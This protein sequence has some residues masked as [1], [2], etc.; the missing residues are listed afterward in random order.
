MHILFLTS[1][2][3]PSPGHMG[4]VNVAW[5]I[6]AGL[7]ATGVQVSVCVLRRGTRFEGPE[8]LGPLSG[9]EVKV[10]FP[11]PEPARGGVW[12][13]LL[14]FGLEES[15][16]EV[17]FRPAVKRLVEELGPDSL[18]LFTSR[19]VAA[20]AGAGRWPPRIVLSETLE[21]R[22][23][24]PRLAF[25]LKYQAGL[26]RYWDA[27]RAAMRWI[28]RSIHS[29]RLMSLCDQVV[30]HADHEAA[31]LRSHG[32]PQASYLPQPMGE[33]LAKNGSPRRQPRPKAATQKLRLMLVAEWGAIANLSAMPSL[34]EDILPALE[35][36]LGGDGFELHLIGAWVELPPRFERPLRRRTQVKI[37]GFVHDLEHEYSLADIVLVPTPIV[38]GARSRIPEAFANGCCV[39]AHSAC[40]VGVPE[41][42]DAENIVLADTGAAVAA[43]AKTLSERPELADRI[44]RAARSTFEEHFD[45]R[46]FCR[47]M[48]S[49]LSQS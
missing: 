10:Y 26:G 1:G 8:L 23:R 14:P 5:G 45:T 44:G 22:G 16:Q 19:A 36:S 46:V 31:W 28:P 6:V 12:R 35:D 43:A 18:W 47:R 32:V 11:E 38:F 40:A 4:T 25:D 34:V 41:L 17:R 21:Y 24:L 15:Y 49:L 27:L 29:L 37:R 13:L 30:V 39:V 3:I 20:A 7:R 33:P 2:Y 42:K 48:V 9:L